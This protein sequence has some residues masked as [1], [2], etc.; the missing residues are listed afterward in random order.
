MHFG[1][2]C[3]PEHPASGGKL[4]AHNCLDNDGSM[5]TS[6]SLGTACETCSANFLANESKGSFKRAT[7]A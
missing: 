2:D 1:G 3:S 5:E 4:G 6:V 7:L